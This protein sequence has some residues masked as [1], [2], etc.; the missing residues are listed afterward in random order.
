MAVPGG[1]ARFE[2]GQA[3]ASTQAAAQ[4]TEG[5]PVLIPV[6]TGRL[7]GGPEFMTQEEFEQLKESATSE[8]C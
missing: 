8:S 2:N 6:F 4:G 5:K 3:N 1:D 7:A